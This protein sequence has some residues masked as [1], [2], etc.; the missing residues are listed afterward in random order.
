MKKKYFG[1]LILQNHAFNTENP[2][3][4]CDI[5]IFTYWALINFHCAIIGGMRV[6]KKLMVILASV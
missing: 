5:K 1:S 6:A 2:N 3:T 4:N